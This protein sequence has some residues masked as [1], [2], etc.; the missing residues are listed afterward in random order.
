MFAPECLCRSASVPLPYSNN[1]ATLANV[2][3]KI[4]SANINT[5]PAPSTTQTPTQTP[6]KSKKFY[7]VKPI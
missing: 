4:E 3:F 7:L 2:S 5:R 1:G 6:Q